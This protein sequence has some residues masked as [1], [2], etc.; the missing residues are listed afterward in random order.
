MTTWF[1]THCHSHYSLLDGLATPE[2]IAERCKKIGLHGSAITDHGSVSGHVAFYTAM[3]NVGVKPIL[4]CE[5]YIC[6]DAATIKDVTNRSLS[7]QVVLAKNYKGWQSLLNIV[8]ASNKPEHF[9]YKPRLDIFSLGDLAHDLISFS[10]HL[11]ST[12]AHCVYD[13]SANEFHYD[14]R[15][16]GEALVEKMKDFFGPDNFFVEIQKICVNDQKLADELADRLRTIAHSTNTPCVATADSHYASPEQAE[17]QQVLLCTNMNQNLAAIKEKIKLGLDVPLR[18]FFDNPKFYI[19]TTEEML[20]IHPEEEVA[21]AQHIADMCEDYELSQPPL[22]PGFEAAGDNVEEYFKERCRE[23]WKRRNV[24]KDK[25]TV[26][27]DR[28]NEEF[29]VI[30]SAGLLPYFLIVQDYIQAAKSRGELVGVGR[31]SSAGCLVSYLL[32]ITDVDPIKYNLLFSRFYNVGRNTGG[33]ISMPDID[34]DFEKDHREDTIEYI[35][36]KY[37][38]DRVAHI[39]TFGTMKG[40]GAIKDVARTIGGISFAEVNSWTKNIPDEAAISDEL[41]KMVEEEGKSSI[42]LWTLRNKAQDFE[43]VCHVDDK[44]NLSGP[45]A[46]IFA[47]AI[48]LEGT[49]RNQ[50]KHASGIVIS[51]IPLRDCIAMVY[52]PKSQQQIA[53]FE[54]EDLEKVG[55]IKFDIL[56]INL[57]DKLA[58][59]QKNTTIDNINPNKLI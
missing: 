30:S 9:Y 15:S 55:P 51:S 4:G 45:Y 31:G 53:G 2:Q 43:G 3:K 44:N 7:H 29:G 33:R 34:T 37:G 47:Q 24:D 10:G 5:L 46:D 25:Q 17:D 11:G 20:L 32:G 35:R 22:L 52:D 21:N 12:L 13:H 19:P 58:D 16:R 28:F 40:R 59:I 42:I 26:Y 39:I 14:W 50:S 38:S 6:S 8:D 41:Q 23:G 57:L 18:G 54:G 49:K 1:S 36:N 56:G 27:V 48:R